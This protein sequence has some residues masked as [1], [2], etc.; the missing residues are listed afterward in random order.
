M[1]VC[2]IISSPDRPSA[3]VRVL[4]LIP[5]LETHGVRADV[6]TFPR[7]LRNRVRVLR[8]CRNY[9]AVVLHKRMLQPLH[10]LLLRHAAAVLVFDF[11]DAVFL[12]DVWPPDPDARWRSFSRG[13][14]F[15]MVTRHSD[16]VLAGNEYLVAEA[17]RHQPRA[18]VL[19]SAV[20]VSGVPQRTDR[21]E[22]SRPVV[23]WVGTQGSLLYMERIAEVLRSVASQLPFEL[24]IISNVEFAMPGVDCR[25]IRWQEETQEQEIAEFDVGLMPL[26]DDPW[27]RGKC[28]YKLLQYMAGGVPFVASAVGMNVEVAAG[29]STGFAVETDEDLG[30]KLLTLLSDPGRRRSMGMKARRLAEERYSIEAVSASLASKLREAAQGR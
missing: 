13:L 14:K 18:H 16:M 8:T 22:H 30:R 5:E 26:S 4:N 11:D 12:R 17:R 19:P 21:G 15:R 28:A 1:N 3:R 10:F 27:A 29:N 20:P 23:G 9:D 25:N 7:G 6:V 2:F 24:R